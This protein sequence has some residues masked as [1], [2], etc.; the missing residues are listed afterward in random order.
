MWRFYLLFILAVLSGLA[1]AH[2]GYHFAV[3]VFDWHEKCEPAIRC[4]LFE[5]MGSSYFTRVMEH[6]ALVSLLQA[7]A[8][9]T[10][11][12]PYFYYVLTGTL[13][14]F[15]LPVAALAAMFASVVG[16]LFIFVGL[17]WIMAFSFAVVALA[18]GLRFLVT[19]LIID[20]L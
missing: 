9:G 13:I 14:I 19:Y 3:M 16:I 4:D 11:F 1:Y 20:R 6:A 8:I 2:Q 5:Y 7:I 15:A 17:F 18:G 12:T 10:G